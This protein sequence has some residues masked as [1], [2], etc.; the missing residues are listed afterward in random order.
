METIE[1]KSYLEFENFVR[2]LKEER[3]AANPKPGKGGQIMQSKLL[4]RGQSDASWSLS[5]TLERAAPNRQLLYHYLELAWQVHKPFEA[6]T[7]KKW[8][9]PDRNEFHKWQ[10]CD[11]TKFSV[12]ANLE[13]IGEYL[14]FL[15]HHGFPSP[16]LDWSESEYVAQFFGFEPKSNADRAIYI[17]QQTSNGSLPCPARMIR[18]AP[19]LRS[20]TPRHFVQHCIFTIATDYSE[21]YGWSFVPHEKIAVENKGTGHHRLWKCIIPGS[22]RNKVLKKLDDHSLNAFSLYNTTDSL[23]SALST[24]FVDLRDERM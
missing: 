13:K 19:W 6:F 11:P 9:I 22:E 21:K 3:A 14:V 20:A 1:F 10:R 16:L 2:D 12:E 15:R 8:N 7:E 4:F 18:Q 24:R 23:A 17:Y 5:T